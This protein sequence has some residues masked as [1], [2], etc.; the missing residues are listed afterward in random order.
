MFY[1]PLTMVLPQLA[2]TI[3]Q[4]TFDFSFSKER[5]TLKTKKRPLLQ[6]SLNATKKAHLHIQNEADGDALLEH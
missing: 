5:Q 3:C 6:T 2:L 4:Q 1:T